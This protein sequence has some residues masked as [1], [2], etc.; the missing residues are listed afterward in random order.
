MKFLPTELPEVI[1]VEPDVH[2]DPRGYFLETYH[3]DKYTAGGIPGPFVQFNHSLSAG[4][5]VRGLHAQI[6]RPQGKLVRVVEGAVLDIAVDIRLDSPTFRRWVGVEISAENFRQI[7]VPSG[8]AHGFAVLTPCAQ[9]DYACTE[10]YDPA[11][12]IVIAWDD[13]ELDIRW[14]LTSPLLSARDA[15]APRLAAWRARL[16][17]RETA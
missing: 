2:R 10:V 14:P 15:A 16:P 5:T 1:V 4:N 8:F 3:R 11:A 12:E 6:E 17:S 9:V 13:P 7:Y